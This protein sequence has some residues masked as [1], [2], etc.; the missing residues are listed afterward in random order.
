[1]LKVEKYLTIRL[2]LVFIPVWALLT[3]LM[4]GVKFQSFAVD[5]WPMS[6]QIRLTLPFL[7]LLASMTLPYALLFATVKWYESM[8]QHNTLSV[9]SSLGYPRWRFGLL[10][11]VYVIA[12]LFMGFALMH[13]FHPMINKSSTDLFT[14]SANYINKFRPEQFSFFK[15]SGNRDMAIFMSK[16]KNNTSNFFVARTIGKSDIFYWIKDFDYKI[17]D[18]EWV[19][20][21]GK[22]RQMVVDN[23]KISQWADFSQH[24]IR[25]PVK[26]MA[27]SV[28]SIETGQLNNDIPGE[29]QELFMRYALSIFAA[30][31][32]FNQLFRFIA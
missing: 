10:K 23:N 15:M 14:K 25:L 13:V 3:F 28:Q 16:N 6:M 1:M 17:D 29:R 26:K 20:D 31:I 12:I 11:L 22:G 5:S 19:I 8:A 27:S 24:Q 32:L 7:P 30:S 9:L 21:F 4:I 2:V 18:N